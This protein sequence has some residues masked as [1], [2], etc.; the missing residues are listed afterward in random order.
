MTG[1]ETQSLM[2]NPPSHPSDPVLLLFKRTTVG[3]VFFNFD[4]VM[5]LQVTSKESRRG[6][7]LTVTSLV[8]CAT[9]QV[10][11]FPATVWLN[12]HQDL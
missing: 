12:P 8:P 7:M 5:Q 10:G 4:P 6:W 11:S 3:K 1:T 9:H 2:L